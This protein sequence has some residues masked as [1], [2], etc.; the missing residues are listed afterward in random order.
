MKI[1]K[2]NAMKKPQISPLESTYFQKFSQQLCKVVW[3]LYF[4]IVDKKLKQK[5]SDLPR[6]T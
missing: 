4:Y 6:D 1:L 2:E 5:G 3:N